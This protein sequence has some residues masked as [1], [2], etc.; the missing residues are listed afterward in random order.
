MNWPHP[1]PVVLCDEWTE[2]QLRAF[3]LVVNRSVSWA[4]WDFGAL[5]LEFA[6]LKK[7]EFDL[8]LTG[9][10]SREI[11]AFTL[12]GNSG[13]DE[14]PPTPEVPASR[15][16]DLWL[17]GPHR[18]LCGDA[19]S[20]TDVSRLLDGRKP[21]LMVTDPPYGVSLDSEWRDRAGL[22]GHVPVEPS[23][24]KH[25]TV[26]HTETRISGDTRAHGLEWS[27][28]SSCPACR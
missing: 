17:C 2:T 8:T 19:T 10:D 20:E 6:E 23:Y 22:N 26:G 4:D 3:R 18:V 12:Q 28:P 25:R 13:E 15:L 1:I 16:G 21:L 9:F 14:A 7:L 5:A 11:D 24:R 27:V